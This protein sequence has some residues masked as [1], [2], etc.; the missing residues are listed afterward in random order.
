MVAAF[1]V[2]RHGPASSS[3]ALRKTAARS[4]KDS[5][6]QPGAA[7]LAAKIAAA[8]STSVALP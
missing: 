3:A 4:S 6:R 2:A 5:A 1:T 7:C 8:T